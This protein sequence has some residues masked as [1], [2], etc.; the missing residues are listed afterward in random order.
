VP[1]TS[2]MLPLGTKAPDFS[3]PTTDGSVVS[4]SDLAE[5]PALLVMFICNHCPYVK[6]VQ[7]EMATLARDYMERGVA[8]VGICSNDPTTHPDDAPAEL[9]R[10]WTSL[11]GRGG[12]FALGP[13]AS[14]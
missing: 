14:R 7:D 11:G 8:V 10:A 5:A 4:L 6:H 2:T 13:R 1:V 3:L 12:R 9:A